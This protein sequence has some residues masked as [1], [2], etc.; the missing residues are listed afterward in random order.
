MARPPKEDP[1]RKVTLSLPTSVAASVELRLIDPIT[2]RPS[3]GAL[4]NLVTGLLRQWL[5]GQVVVND[6]LTITTST[7]SDPKEQTNE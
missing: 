4:S 3:Y 6:A 1:P 2:M 5:A 7:T